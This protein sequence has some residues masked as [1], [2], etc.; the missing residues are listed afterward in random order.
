MAKNEGSLWSKFCE[1]TRWM[2]T[3]AAK[4]GMLF[5]A[6]AFVVY[7]VMSSYSLHQS[8]QSASPAETY[9]LTK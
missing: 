4:V 9:E 2:E 5:V 1:N 8:T 6:G 3:P 7:A